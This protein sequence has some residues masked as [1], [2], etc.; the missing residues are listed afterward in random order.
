LWAFC[1]YKT[2]ANKGE[3]KMLLDKSLIER[4]IAMATPGV[5][6]ILDSKGTTW[7]RKGVH[8]CVSGPGVAECE[9]RLGDV[10]SPWNPNWGDE[11]NFGYIAEKKL[12][13]AMRLQRNTSEAVTNTPWLLQDR[14]FLYPGG[15]YRDGIGVGVSG[16]MGRADEAIAE[17]ILSIIIML[18]RLDT[19]KRIAE[20]KMEI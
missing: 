12:I 16:G 15:A 2:E 20:H 13:V 6:A 7:A 5:V 17:I 19:D 11:R 1:S 14:E 18:L 8:V 9:F 3:R 4:A 10:N